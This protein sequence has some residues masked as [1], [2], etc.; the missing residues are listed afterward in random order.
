MLKISTDLFNK[1]GNAPYGPSAEAL[2][3]AE[4]VLKEGEDQINRDSA[5]F[6]GRK[7]LQLDVNYRW[8]AVVF[9]ERDEGK[10]MK[11]VADAYGVNSHD[12]RAGD[13]A[14]D[15]PGLVILTGDVQGTMTRLHDLF[16]PS[17][18]V[19]LV[20]ATPSSAAD[21]LALLKPLEGFGQDS[22]RRSLILTKGSVVDAGWALS[23]IE[24][25]VDSEGHAYTGYGVAPASDGAMVVIIRPDGMVGAFAKTAVA[26][27]KY[28]KVVFA[29]M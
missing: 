5:W 15:A 8:S 18:H 22:F 6:R 25:L 12:T 10:D 16:S 3:R 23:G 4:A 19:A 14:P 28:A 29:S 11:A 13:R 20:F 26:V 2:N 27:E 1:I 24:V 7:F 21:A 17:K 9:D